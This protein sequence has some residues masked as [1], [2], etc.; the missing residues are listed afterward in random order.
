MGDDIGRDPVQASQTSPHGQDGDLMKLRFIV[1]LAVVCACDSL[2]CQTAPNSVA[3][4]AS[5]KVGNNTSILPATSVALP[6][7]GT[8]DDAVDVHRRAT[9]SSVAGQETSD[10]GVSSF[11][12]KRSFNLDTLDV[13][14]WWSASPADC[15]PDKGTCAQNA[16]CCQTGSSGWCCPNGKTCDYDNIS[17]K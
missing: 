5:A 14:L 7:T 9:V 1:L 3:N 16:H 11:R 6:G 4:Q 13:A 17:C 2:W 15:G 10:Y 12:N 8:L